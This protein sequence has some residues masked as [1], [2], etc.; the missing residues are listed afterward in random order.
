M[1]EP[2]REVRDY[3]PYT[4]MSPP[5]NRR[6]TADLGSG[7]STIAKFSQADIDRWEVD[8]YSCPYTSELWWTER[9][10]RGGRFIAVHTASGV[11]VLSRY[12]SETGCS[13]CGMGDV[14]SD[15]GIWRALRGKHLLWLGFR[16]MLRHAQQRIDPCMT[17][18]KL[19]PGDV[20][21]EAITTLYDVY[22]A[23][24]V[25]HFVQRGRRYSVR[26]G[27]DRECECWEINQ[28]KSLIKLQALARG[29]LVRQYLWSPYHELG[30]RRLMRQWG[31]LQE[32][33]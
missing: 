21:Y 17:A 31:T 10:R 8:E 15:D 25:T 9:W 2:Y 33:S 16:T 7:W 6:D 12:E 13:S 23:R 29:W 32:G 24:L 30:R 19:Q 11:A 20:H 3:P 5:P 27:W 18:R 1:E 28:H 22:K 26:A 14:D 4:D